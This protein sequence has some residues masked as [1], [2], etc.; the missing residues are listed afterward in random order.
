MF[1][2]NIGIGDHFERIKKIGIFRLHIIAF[3]VE[4]L[5]AGDI[6]KNHIR[7]RFTGF[8]EF[9]DPYYFWKLMSFGEKIFKIG[10]LVQKL[11]MF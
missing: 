3:S 5:T 4:N 10:Q 9:N 6:G 8:F 2:E 1:S 7:S 11:H